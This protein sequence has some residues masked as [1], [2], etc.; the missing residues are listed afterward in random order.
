MKY[1]RK[2]VNKQSMCFNYILMEG[3]NVEGNVNLRAQNAGRRVLDKQTYVN[4]SFK[5]SSLSFL[6]AC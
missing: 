4:V 6:F 5:L 2:R 3:L 1:K